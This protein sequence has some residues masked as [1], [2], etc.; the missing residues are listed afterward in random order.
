MV[1]GPGTDDPDGTE[2]EGALTAGDRPAVDADSGNADDGRP[3]LVAAV[4]GDVDET[5]VDAET[6]ET[7]NRVTAVGR[8]PVTDLSRVDVVCMRT[9]TRCFADDDGQ[10]MGFLTA[11]TDRSGADDSTAPI[12]MTDRTNLSIGCL[13]MLPLLALAGNATC[14]RYPRGM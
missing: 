4:G 3:S 6:G 10:C 12:A 8:T 2:T 9:H 1:F 13:V 5:G 14:P 7:G 11:D